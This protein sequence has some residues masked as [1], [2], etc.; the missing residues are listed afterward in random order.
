MDTATIE[1]DERRFSEQA[2]AVLTRS[3]HFD[4]NETLFLNRQLEHVRAEI[5]ETRFANLIGRQLVPAA[6]DIPIGAETWTTQV[7]TTYGLAK[8]IANYADDLPL[9]DA[10]MTDYSFPVRTLGDGYQWSWLDMQRAALNSLPLQMMKAKAARRAMELKIDQIIATGDANHG[11]AGLVNNAAVTLT[12]VPTGNWAAA[13][14]ATI[15]ADINFMVRNIVTTTLEMFR[16]NTIVLDPVSY[17][18]IESMVYGVD[19]PTTVLKVIQGNHPG[20]TILPWTRLTNAN[21]AGTGPRAIAY[22]RTPEVLEFGLPL[23]FQDLPPQERNLAFVVPCVARISSV[24]I[25]QPGA[26]TY[27]D[28]L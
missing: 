10:S 14:A 19:N 1:R 8:V 27:A 12:N 9:V 18:R 22:E 7:S 11:L 23:D 17:A 6:T 5:R 3:G 4:A 28:N 2:K 26:I 13:A 25:H 24:A 16:P 15:L 20:L 21:V